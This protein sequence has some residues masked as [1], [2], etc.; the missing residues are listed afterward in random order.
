MSFEVNG[1]R[2][3]LHPLVLGRIQE[4]QARATKGDVRSHKLLAGLNHLMFGVIPRDPGHSRF[5]VGHSLG[6]AFAHWRRAKMYQRYRV[7]F[8]FSSAHRSIV[9]LW[10][11]DEHSFRA[12][13]AATDAYATFQRMIERGTPPDDLDQLLWESEHGREK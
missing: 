5:Y 6:S 3:L 2:I 10:I 4:W 9:L 1:W 7:F 8:R 11:N 12:Y 13:G